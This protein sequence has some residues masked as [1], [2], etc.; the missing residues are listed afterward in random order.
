MQHTL[1][2]F[3]LFAA[4]AAS[5][6]A[7]ATHNRAGEIIVCHEAG[8]VYRV[9]IITHTKLSAPADRPE[10]VIDFGDG[11]I[12]TIPRSAIQDDPSRDL[13]RSEYIVLHSYPNL[14]VYT[15]SFDDQNRNAGVVNVPN[16]IAQS[17]CVKTRLVIG[18]ATGNNCSVRFLRSPIQDACVNRLWIHNPAAVDADGDSLSY[19]PAVCLGLGCLP[20]GGY[21]FPTPNY[22]ID[23]TTGT[24]TWNAPSVTG[25]YNI[26]FIVREWRRVNG[27]YVNVGWVTRDMQITVVPCDNQPPVISN[28]PDTCV[29]A[30]TILSFNVQAS[31][32][33]VGQQVTL[34]AQGQPFV[35]PSSPAIFPPPSPAP[36]VTGTFTW[37]TNCS[38]VRTQSYQVVFSAQDNGQPV[39]LQNVSTMNIRV[40]APPPLDP[41]ATPS[42]NAIQLNWSPS[43]CSNAEGYR[44]YRR[45]GLYGYVPDNCETGV[46]AY[47]GYTLIG[48]VQGVGNANYLDE[49]DLVVGNQYC[50]MVVAYFTE[51][52]ESIASE[53]FCAILDRQVPVI[54]HVSVGTTDVTTGRDTIRWSN[55]YDLDT[56][57]RPGPYQFKLYRGNGF[58]V[59]DEL[60]WTSA[61]HP[62]LAHPDTSYL[63]LDLDTRTQAHAYRVEFLGNN[64][65]DAI[66]SSN[67][68][69]S[70]FINTLPADEQ[71][72]VQWSL[73]TPW[74]N[75]LY[76]VFR[77]D[78]TDW[79][80]VGT[81][82]TDS[83][84]DTG[85]ENGVEYCYYVRSTGA[86][87]DPAIVAPLINYSQEV[88][89]VPEDRT[90]PCT[91]TLA[92][93]ND[94]EQPLNTLT[95][96]NP[97]VECGDLDTY[98]YS[99]WF[100]DSLGGEFELI[101]TIVGAE[102]TFFE[103]INGTS[104]AG[105]YVVTAVDS[106][107][108]ES[109]FSTEVCGDNC[110][111]YRLP[112][113]F[114]PNGDGQNDLFGP[115]LPYRG[116]NSIDLQIFNRWGQ[117]VFETQDPD[118][119][120]KGTYLETN[121]PV[122]DGVY[123]YICNVIFS[124]LNGD[125]ILV[126]KGHVQLLGSG[127][128]PRAN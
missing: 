98:G 68:A 43:I 35:V 21:S 39:Q 112:N 61:F 125:E 8:S 54:T 118:I 40:V 88:C 66:G 34:T 85:L 46:P 2:L 48:S 108:N 17:F 7:W 99:V 70:V 80:L 75:S 110:P 63:D 56:L 37:V 79:V 5:A 16:S 15:L 49:G 124:R 28:V 120:W 71:L 50:Y 12:D 58:N 73:N 83:Y 6:V 86:Y 95:W 20:I 62:F 126:L 9:T 127:I 32:P 97:A 106:L 10:L 90:P 4:F 128:Q 81:S 22:N 1:R 87:S 69:S 93:D 30:G 74:V 19:E 3:L 51:G 38:H 11:E 13:R 114:T 47:T 14:G 55:A 78:G 91:P 104:V 102:N 53:E 109:P 122:P 82:T 31:D 18:A 64:G 119:D 65:A 103:H 72:I 60:I 113:V 25:E 117:V 76:E 111:E 96:T 101:A 57:A 29:V 42:G 116:V 27:V 77:F 44:I 41:T 123:F 23:P 89:G 52:S 100:A 115:Y 105:C 26:A 121:E 84:T 36:S 45:S 67:V 33:D 92:I 59:A 24:I 94:C 107:G